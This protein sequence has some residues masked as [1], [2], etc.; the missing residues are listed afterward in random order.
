MRYHLFT[1]WDPKHNPRTIDDHQYILHEFGRVRWAVLHKPDVFGKIDLT[2]KKM[3]MLNRQINKGHNTY[4]FI[5]SKAK[6]DPSLH[7]GLVEKLEGE[8]DD[9]EQ[10]PLIP[11]Y[12]KSLREKR[13]D[14]RFSFWMTLA[15]LKRV[16]PADDFLDVYIPESVLDDK[17]IGAYPC[18]VSLRKVKDYFPVRPDRQDPTV[19]VNSITFARRWRQ[20]VESPGWFVDRINRKVLTMELQKVL[21]FNPRAIELLKE[22]KENG[23]QTMKQL[24]KGLQTT[25]DNIYHLKWKTN[26]PFRKAGYGDLI[27]SEG[28]K[29]VLAVSP[30]KIKFK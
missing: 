13:P 2:R 3:E 12:Y 17:Y 1:I 4:L 29:Y 5:R 22:L 23:P 14:L 15:H 25:Q 7:V 8:R 24:K 19:K 20:D 6:W 18:V 16:I 11:D 9:W 26:A 28:H 27:V 21:I 30:S 10:D